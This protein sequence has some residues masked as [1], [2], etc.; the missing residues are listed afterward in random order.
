M[1]LYV[2]SN[3][4]GEVFSAKVEVVDDNHNTVPVFQ[5][6]CDARLERCRPTG[7]DYGG[8]SDP[9]KNELT[10]S[11]SATGDMISGHDHNGIR[12]VEAATGY[13]AVMGEHG[14]GRATGG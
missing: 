11:Y 1:P 8:A 7:N 2:I 13:V 12:V 9:G 3:P 4:K 5:I 6:F 14:S 10:C